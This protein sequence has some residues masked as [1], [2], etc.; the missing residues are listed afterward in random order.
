LSDGLVNKRKSQKDGIINANEEI[1]P[2]A[3]I[4]DIKLP[5]GLTFKNSLLVPS[6]STKLISVKWLTQDL[7][8]VALVFPSYC[9][10]QRLLTKEI[11]SHGTKR[12]G[13]YY[14]DNLKT[15]WVNLVE[16]IIEDKENKV[17][18]WHKQLGHLLFGY[19]KKLSP[20]LFLGLDNEELSCK[21]YVEAKIH[22][23]SYF[24]SMNKALLFLI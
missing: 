16:R 14:L 11:I 24:D 4:G 21:M 2:V 3:K 13:L 18:L 6:L 12:D 20:H 22:I 7:N 5:S 9:V 19:L 8:C 1:H 23:T 17:I 10:F 15:R